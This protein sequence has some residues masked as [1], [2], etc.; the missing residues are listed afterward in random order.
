M[1]HGSGGSVATDPVEC[2]WCVL[3]AVYVCLKM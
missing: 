3:V 1:T 2:G